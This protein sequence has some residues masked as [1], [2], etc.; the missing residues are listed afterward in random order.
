MTRLPEG[1]CIDTTEVTRAQ[2]SAWLAT[3]PSIAGQASACQG[4]STFAPDAGCMGSA[5]DPKYV[6]LENCDNHPQVCVD[7]CDAYAYCR[8]VGK[9][10]CGKI[11]GG[12]NSP[13]DFAN[14]SLSQWHN[15]CSSHGVNTYPYGTNYDPIACNGLGLWPQSPPPYKYKTLPVG[16]KATCASEIPSYEGVFDLSGNV[17]EFED[18]CLTESD[19]S[20]WC[21]IRGGAF[22]NV[23]HLL[24]ASEVRRLITSVDASVGF[25]CCS[26][27]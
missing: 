17:E 11:G 27:P 21:N 25:R 9:R 1:Y 26:S 15:A 8:A 7:W 5:T 18:S 4:N 23:S 14:P 19:Q 13:T 2:Y 16:S 10:L 6:C 24:C 3:N 20:V 12:S 22:N